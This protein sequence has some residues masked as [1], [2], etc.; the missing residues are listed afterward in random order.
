MPR[1]AGIIFIEDFL[2]DV[3]RSIAVL[4][5]IFAAIALLLASI[6]LYT[7]IANSVA[8]RTPEIG[9]RMAIGA[10]ANGILKLVFLQGMLP[11]GI[12][13]AF[14]L[15]A[16]LAVMPILKSALVQVS[17]ADPITFLGASVVLISAALLGC[18]IPGRRATRINPQEALRRE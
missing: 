10:T 14:G 12:G 2:R 18:L 8:Q 17:P 1:R 6:G 16:S 15:G 7:V 13:L 5:L 9:I 3:S 4:F 11:L